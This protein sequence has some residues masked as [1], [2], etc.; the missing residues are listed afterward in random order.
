MR[1][2][3]ELDNSDSLPDRAKKTRKFKWKE[4]SYTVIYSILVTQLINFKSYNND[5]ND[6][7]SDTSSLVTEV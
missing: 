4:V 5:D 3:R 2:C 1:N 6:S 7:D